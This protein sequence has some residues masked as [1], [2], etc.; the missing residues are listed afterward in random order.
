MLRR[1]FRLAGTSFDRGIEDVVDFHDINMLRSH[2]ADR[3]RSG[4][5]EIPEMHFSQ[6]DQVLLLLPRKLVLGGKATGGS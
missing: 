4:S 3:C 6:P 5:I 1:A 2:L